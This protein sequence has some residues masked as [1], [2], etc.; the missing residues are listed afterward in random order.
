MY[1][2]NF[3]TW[4]DPNDDAVVL[5]VAKGIKSVDPNHIHT[6]ELNYFTSGS[7]DDA[8]REPIVN[9][10]GAYIYYPTHAQVLKEYNRPNFRPVFME[11]AITSF[12]IIAIPMVAPLQIRADR[13]AGRRYRPAL[14]Q[15]LYLDTPLWLAF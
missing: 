13:N 9:L 7:L 15:R 14:W 3:Q 6:T 11:E 2:S 4:A 5:A 10:D 8:R 12:K 1:V